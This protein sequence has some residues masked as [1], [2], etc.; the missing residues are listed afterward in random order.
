[1]A[2]T[3]EKDPKE[4]EES[5]E[6]EIAGIPGKKVVVIFESYSGSK[7]RGYTATVTPEKKIFVNKDELKLKELKDM[8]KDEKE[9]FRESSNTSVGTSSGTA[10]E[11]E[12]EEEDSDDDEKPE[13]E[14]KGD[15]EKKKQKERKKQTA[16][17]NT[18]L[19]SFYNSISHPDIYHDDVRT[20]LL[21]AFIR[22]LYFGETL[23]DKYVA[24]EVSIRVWK[25][26][27]EEEEAPGAP[28]R[29]KVPREV[30]HPLPMDVG[31]AFGF[32]FER[33]IRILNKKTGVLSQ[34]QKQ[35]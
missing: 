29:G 33:A 16:T 8:T 34:A 22:C 20:F 2:E 5:E 11:S 4:K 35:Q 9:I 23:A 18:A 1:M 6:E 31:N 13:K 3:K 10:S 27:S 26:D 7:S 15:D 25:E 24:D 32:D 14:E 12:E 17:I 21:N 19:S 30:S 28:R